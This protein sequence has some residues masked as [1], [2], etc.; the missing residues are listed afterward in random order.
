M[1]SQ[2]LCQAQIPCRHRVSSGFVFPGISQWEGSLGRTLHFE[3]GL[4]WG[5][6]RNLSLE[7]WLP[8][9]LLNS[10]ETLQ[11]QKLSCFT[12]LMLGSL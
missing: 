9:V 2:P 1:G 12:L 5:A 10:K 6:S 4:K 11:L 8:A 7:P 3:A